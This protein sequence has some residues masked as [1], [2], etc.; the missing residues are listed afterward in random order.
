[1][2]KRVLAILLSLILAV[3]FT[4]IAAAE[5]Y[6]IVNP[7]SGNNYLPLNQL[8]QPETEPDYTPEPDNTMLTL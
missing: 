2:K 1:M 4:T 7:P 6:I 8:N 3:S 5:D